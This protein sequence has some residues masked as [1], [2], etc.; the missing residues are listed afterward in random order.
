MASTEAIDEDDL[1]LLWFSPQRILAGPIT[2]EID[3]SNHP[4]I[5]R[6]ISLEES[7]K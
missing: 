2:K 6:S 4:K 1:K 5:Q 7:N 3:G